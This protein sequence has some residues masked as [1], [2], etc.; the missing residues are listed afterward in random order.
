MILEN[1]IDKQYQDNLENTMTSLSFPWFFNKW[2]DEYDLPFE[3]H[4]V[5]NSFQLS[6]VFYDS[7][8]SMPTYNMVQP[9]IKRITEKLNIR[10]YHLVRVKANLTTKHNFAM[11]KY[12]IPHV[13]TDPPCRSIIYYVNNSDGDTV[14]FNERVGTKFGR[15]TIKEESKPV[16]GSIFSFDGSHYHAG[17]FPTDNDTRIVINIVLK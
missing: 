12:Q 6:H 11:Q 16:K 17:R 10:Q 5:I 14:V 1:I 4:R 13:D 8:A 15:F 2:I 3:D 7:G 9:L